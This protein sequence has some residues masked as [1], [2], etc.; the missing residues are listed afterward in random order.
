MN[1]NASHLACFTMLALVGACAVKPDQPRQSI[2]ETAACMNYRAMMVAPMPPSEIQ[3][4]KAA[5]EQS[6]L[7]P[8]TKKAPL[9]EES[10][11]RSQLSP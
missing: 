9:Q 11:P 7:D 1:H 2:A 6:R 4:L 3:R 5:C 8:Q 10:A